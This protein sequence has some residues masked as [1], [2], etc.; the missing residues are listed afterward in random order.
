M[1]ESVPY[2]S[3]KDISFVL[4][5][6]SGSWLTNSGPSVHQLASMEQAAT[7]GSAPSLSTTS[8]STFHGQR[9]CLVRI[10]LPDGCLLLQVSL[11]VA[12][13]TVRTY[14]RLGTRGK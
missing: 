12:M 10:T 6:T 7:S 3:I 5:P 14:N 13:A 2:S 4:S 1:E 8:S 11:V 9:Y